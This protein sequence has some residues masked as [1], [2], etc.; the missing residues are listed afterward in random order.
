V[1]NITV[2]L[3]LDRGLKHSKES[4]HFAEHV[5]IMELVAREVT[6]KTTLRKDIQLEAKE[7]V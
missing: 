6:Y 1:L 3:A 2:P 7:S 5:T 4:H